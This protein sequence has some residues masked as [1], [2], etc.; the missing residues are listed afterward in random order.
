MTSCTNCVPLLVV[1]KHYLEEHGWV[2]KEPIEGFYQIICPAEK[3]KF[4]FGDW[5]QIA[6]KTRAIAKES[7]RELYTPKWCRGIWRN[8]VL[9]DKTELGRL[10]LFETNWEKFTSKFSS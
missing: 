10:L 4:S 2:S 3:S 1:I 9:R 5:E 6:K 7:E 8:I